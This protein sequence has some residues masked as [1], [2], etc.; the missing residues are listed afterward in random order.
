MSRLINAGFARLFKN[1]VFYVIVIFSAVFGI[2][3]GTPG[4]LDKM[5]GAKGLESFEAADSQD[6]DKLLFPAPPMPQKCYPHA[7]ARKTGKSLKGE[8]SRFCVSVCVL[9]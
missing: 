8:T 9:F 1:K 4:A 5:D 3:Q 2:L 6:T 7:G